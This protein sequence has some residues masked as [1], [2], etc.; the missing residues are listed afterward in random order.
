M[1][2]G[3]CDYPFSAPL[4]KPL[5]KYRSNRG[6]KSSIGMTVMMMMAD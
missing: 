3:L 1:D 6:Y 2:F 5:V 4:T